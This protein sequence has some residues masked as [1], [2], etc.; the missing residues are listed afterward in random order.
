MHHSRLCALMLDCGPDDFEVGVD[1]WNAALGTQPVHSGDPTDPYVALPG[2]STELRVELQR[3]GG[4]SRVH[5]DIETDD[6]AAEVARLEALGATRERQIE[7]WWV[8]RAPSGHTFCVVPPQ[9]D[10]FPANARRWD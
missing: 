7:T 10:D 1:F 8:M 5:V 6:V 9:H 4:P 2:V 3:F